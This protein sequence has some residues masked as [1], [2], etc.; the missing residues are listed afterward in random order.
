[1]FCFFLSFHSIVLAFLSGFC[2]QWLLLWHSSGNY[3]FFSW[4][5]PS[6]LRSF[7]WGRVVPSPSLSHL[8]VIY[9]RIKSDIFPFGLQSTIVIIY[10]LVQIVPAFAIS[11][12]FR[13]FLHPFDIALSKNYC[14]TFLF[15]GTTECF[16]FTL[17]FLYLRP[18]TNYFSK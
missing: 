17:Y 3:L 18:G 16:R 15:S 8:F 11:H 6:L 12:S 13:L 14:N 7:I 4:S 5:L 1:M 2:L 9:I 10:F